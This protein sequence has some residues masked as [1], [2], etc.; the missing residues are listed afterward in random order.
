MNAQKNFGKRFFAPALLAAFLAFYTLSSVNR[1]F[2]GGPGSTSVQILKT[3]VGPRAMGMGGSFV[4]VA[5]DIYS[6]NYNPAGLGQLYMPEAS[7][8]YLSGFSDSR[9]QFLAFGMP[10]PFNGVLT[11][12]DKAGMAFS[13]LLSDSGEFTRR[14]IDP[15]NGTVSS[16]KMN[17]ESTRVF[18]LTY[19]EKVYSDE[20]NIEGYNA[21]IDQFIGISAK[22]INSELLEKYSASAFA[23]DAGWLMRESNL[24]L[25]FGAALANYGTGI[26][27][28]HETAP[29]PSILKIGAAYQRPTVM[30]Q[31]IL[32]T[33]GADFYT[34]ENLKSLK[35]GLEYHFEKIFNARLGYKGE[36][37]N[38]GLSMGLGIHHEGFALDF[39]MAL[40]NEVFN[41][42][43][44]SVSYKF[45]GW[46]RREYKKAAQ[47][48]EATDQE[49]QREQ[50][51]KKEP[52]KAKKQE[53]PPQKKEPDFLWLY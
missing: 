44:V 33:A 16:R 48:R 12:L 14:D 29:L 32:L 49:R 52:V 41:T 23:F 38:K 7:A 31:S 5:D 13:A 34:Q 46:R 43:Q 37:D 26:K 19:G 45:S 17:A 15:S 8:L 53:P 3:D 30:D 10:M 18:S 39:A 47:Y 36:K 1:T 25:T 51:P 4:A 22:Y 40:S 28:L 6:V 20:L 27:Y 2:A 42:S 35:A 21:K 11:G 24:G 9:L 50:A